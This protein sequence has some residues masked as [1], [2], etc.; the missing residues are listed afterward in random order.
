MKRV[1]VSW[2]LSVS[3]AVSGLVASSRRPALGVGSGDGSGDGA[4]CT[5]F[6]LTAYAIMM[7]IGHV[8]IITGSGQ[9]S[10]EPHVPPQSGQL[11]HVPHWFGVQW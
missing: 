10:F 6:G 5:E 8:I 9:Q 7:G 3:M 2:S 4:G 11:A 1:I